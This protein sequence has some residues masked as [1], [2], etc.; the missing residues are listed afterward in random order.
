MIRLS[1]HQRRFCLT[2]VLLLPNVAAADGIIVDKIY[3]P[4]VH[5]LE[6]EI[7]ARFVGQTD[8]QTPDLQKY[9]LGFGR[10]ISD[11]WAVELYT[12][13]FRTPGESVSV[14]TYELEAKWQLT[15]QGE[16][17]ADWGLLFELER[18]TEENSWEL[19]TQLLTARDFGRISTTANLGVL[20]ERGEKIK[21]EFETTLRLQARYRLRESFEPAVELHVGQ[22]TVAFGPTILGLV[23]IAKGRKLRWEFGVFTGIDKKSPDQIIKANFEFEF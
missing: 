14:D 11:R 10:T 16:Y 3:D 17:A 4:Y 9:S 8:N 20:Y 5:P 6:K 18:G 23:R 2:A 19:T 1:L 15:E 13:A 21:N 7:E 22:N 12:I